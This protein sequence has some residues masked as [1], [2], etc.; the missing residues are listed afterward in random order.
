MNCTRQSKFPGCLGPGSCLVPTWA[1][2]PNFCLSSRAGVLNSTAYRAIQIRYVKTLSWGCLGT[3]RECCSKLP[4]CRC[5]EPRKSEHLISSRK[6]RD[7]DFCVKSNHSKMLATDSCENDTSTCD[8]S[9]G[10]SKWYIQEFG[11]ICGPP[12]C[13]STLLSPRHCFLVLAYSSSSRTIFS[14]IRPRPISKSS[15][16]KKHF[17][18]ATR[19]SAP[20]PPTMS[21]CAGVCILLQ[22]EEGFLGS[23]A[24]K[25][26]KIQGWFLTG[27]IN[28]VLHVFGHLYHIFRA[29]VSS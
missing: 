13:I 10:N 19:P 23:F 17:V 6:A 1:C 14:S 27:K 9:S 18:T 28:T 3:C 20:S 22:G 21:V 15:N 12:V 4:P 29:L 7:L 16:Y 26:M 25:F 5:P 24:K 8:N 11:L 2:R